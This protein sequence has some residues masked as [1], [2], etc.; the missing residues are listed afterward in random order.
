MYK[1]SPR[2]A[3]LLT[4]GTEWINSL[5]IMALF[6]HDFS[7]L[8]SLPSPQTPT[9]LPPTAAWLVTFSKF[10]RREAQPNPCIY[11]QENCNKTIWSCCWIVF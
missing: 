6:W 8:P 2:E 10:Y 4:D 1:T 3:L 5:I 9:P 11:L 7:F